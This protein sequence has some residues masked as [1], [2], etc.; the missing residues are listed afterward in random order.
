MDKHKRRLL[1]YLLGINIGLIILAFSKNWERQCGVILLIQLTTTIIFSML[2][3]RETIFLV[4]L[5]S[6]R[7]RKPGL[8]TN[9][10]LTISTL[11][12][13][14]C[15]IELVLF[16]HQWIY[17]PAAGD[18]FA[19]TLSIPA[20]SEK[21]PAIV[22]GSHI[23]FYWH[24]ILHLR[25][26]RGMRRIKPFPSKKENVFRIMLVGDSLT[27]GHGVEEGNTYGRVLEGIL[28]EG[29]H[30]EVLN[31]GICGLQSSD[32]VEIVLEFAPILK[33]DLFVYGICLNDFLPSGV[34]QYKNNLR[35][36]FPL[37]AHIKSRMVRQTYIGK[38]FERAYD[39]LLI[40][41]GI[42]SDFYDDILENFKN[43]Q[44]RFAD[45]L[46][47][48]NSFVVK[49]GFPPILAVVFHQHPV[50]SGRGHRIAQIAEAA[51]QKAGMTVVPTQEYFKK[52][53]D[54]SMRVSK[55]EGHPNRKA[56]RILAEM[57]APVIRKRSELKKYKK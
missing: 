27:Y 32:I 56:H 5:K 31:L 52:Y 47:R 3:L 6:G 18:S 54:Q 33:P 53:D 38:L 9:L 24:G 23:G 15:L 42:R 10:I 8:F 30:A 36:P 44:G 49:N 39:Q 25:N 43:Y 46:L 55:W 7:E 19:K 57:L 34:G 51:A 17:P 41:I 4:S 2:A 12:I 50:Y 11:L 28:S 45:D 40:R 20:E 16:L 26:K 13:C 1:Y 22:K 29:Y 37:P 48:M 21:R 35:W 14:L